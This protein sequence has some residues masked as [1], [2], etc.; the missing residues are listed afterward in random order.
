[1][2]IQSIQRE[3]DQLIYKR[4]Q[5]NI[6]I[7]YSNLVELDNIKNKL[8]QNYDYN[9]QEHKS[10]LID[11]CEKEKEMNIKYI[12]ILSYVEFIDNINLEKEFRY[13]LIDIQKS[14]FY[15]DY[16]KNDKIKEMENI[17]KI[18]DLINEV[19]KNKN[20][21]FAFQEFKNLKLKIYNDEVRKIL[22]ENIE[23]CK[24][25]ILNNEIMNIKKL[26]EKKCFEDAIE[27]SEQLFKE[28]K[29]EDFLFENISKI[30]LDILEERIESKIKEGE[31]KI[32]EIKKYE[33]FINNNQ[34]N[35]DNYDE[36]K[37][38]LENF[39]LFF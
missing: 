6:K 21:S 31:R 23:N 29:N 15:K 9:L 27:K 1:M 33:D 38:K 8:Q 19:E 30:Y 35:L 2:F 4:K 24:I 14:S 26:I 36:Y 10:K 34:Y 12:I 7:C 22:A 28:Y 3:F 39:T 37:E 5:K 16:K 32:K 20:Y 13:L 11:M 25:G 17:V 18:F